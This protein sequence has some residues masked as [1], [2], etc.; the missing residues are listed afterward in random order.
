M[1]DTLLPDD[2]DD[3]NHRLFP[4]SSQSQF[5]MTSPDV[6]REIEHSIRIVLFDIR[7]NF[8]GIFLRK[9]FPTAST[10]IAHPTGGLVIS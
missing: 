2:D 4:F 3:T 8:M 7:E 10:F 5:F 1:G 9:K 6:I